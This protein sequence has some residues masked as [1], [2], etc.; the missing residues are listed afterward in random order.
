MASHNVPKYQ[1][2]YSVLRQ[3][4]GS[5]DLAAGEKLPAQQELADEF[6]VTLMTLRQ[7]VAA[8]AADGLAWAERGRG[9]FVADRPIDI[10][11][12]NLSSFAEQMRSAGV[13]MTTD[14]LTVDVVD[15]VGKPA[16]A[17]KLGTDAALLCLV[18]RRRVGGVPVSLQHSFMAGDLG[19]PTAKF[20]RIGESLYD[21][22]REHT[23]WEVV[24]AQETVGAV[25]L[26]SAQAEILETD[27]GKPAL[28]SIRTSINQFGHSFLYD[29]ALLV[30]GRCSLAAD[31]T[32]GRLALDF[33]VEPGHAPA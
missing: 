1:A 11:V 4:I 8:L 31:R 14:V 19:L 7:A 32:A 23:G 13:D 30:G 28:L 15:S 26:T 21:A 10:G 20:E 33:V 25:A 12:G 9:T 6:G 17:A 29:E 3:R 24:E 16:A 27:E 22:I 18:R 5:G 2:I